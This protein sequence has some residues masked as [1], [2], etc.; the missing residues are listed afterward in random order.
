MTNSLIHRDD[1]LGFAKFSIKASSETDDVRICQMN[2]LQGN[3]KPYERFDV[4]TD[5]QTVAFICNK[6]AL[7]FFKF[8]K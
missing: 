8:Y 4:T 2:P 6:T 3:D 5:C 7:T 1:R